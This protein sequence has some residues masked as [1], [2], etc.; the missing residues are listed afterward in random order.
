MS[1]FGKERIIKFLADR[2]FVGKKWFNWLKSEEIDFAIRIKKNT[3]ATNSRGD[4]VQVQQK[5][6]FFSYGDAMFLAD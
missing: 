1:Q 4:F 2:E 3:K 6:R 5:Y